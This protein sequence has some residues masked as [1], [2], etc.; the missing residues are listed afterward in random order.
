LVDVLLHEKG[1]AP[2]CWKNR[3]SVAKPSQSGFLGY[4]DSLEI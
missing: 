2:A 4:I 1:L 3:L